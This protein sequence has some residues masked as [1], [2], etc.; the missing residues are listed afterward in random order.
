M[1]RK[2]EALVLLSESA[3]LLREMGHLSDLKN[4]LYV[5]LLIFVEMDHEEELPA[6]YKEYEDL[7]LMLGKMDDLLEQIRWHADLMIERERPEKALDLTRES[8]RILRNTD[9]KKELRTVLSIQI[10]GVKALGPEEELPALYQEYEELCLETGET[11]DLIEHLGEHA[12]LMNR[13][14]KHEEALGLLQ[15]QEQLMRD[16]GNTENLGMNLGNQGLTLS[17]ID[18][19]EEAMKLHV[20]SGSVFEEQGNIIGVSISYANQGLIYREW[21][22]HEEALIMHEK[23]EALCR[24]A[25]FADGLIRSLGYQAVALYELKR[26]KEALKFF[27]Q[28]EKAAKKEKAEIGELF[29]GIRKLAEKELITGKNKK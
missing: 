23:E 13:M 28:Q 27:R 16:T 18:R 11:N 5:L 9:N 21:G 1:D 3:R 8:V 24:K 10:L 6:L 12:D 14:E 4:V 20:M 22:R 26:Y 17:N 25:K 15:Q 19:F 29:S 7:C 2:D